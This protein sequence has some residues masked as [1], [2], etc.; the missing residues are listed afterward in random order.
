MCCTVHEARLSNTII[1]AAKANHPVHG[2]VN[3]LGYQ[4]TVEAY[5]SEPNA[6]I[7]PVPA[8]S[9]SAENIVD[10]TLFSEIL[11][12]Y[13]SE[14]EE[15]TFGEDDDIQIRG[16][17]A[18]SAAVE[19][20]KSGSYTVLLSESLASA[21][22]ALAKLDLPSYSKPTLPFRMIAPLSQLYRKWPFAVCCF[23]AVTRNQEPFFLWYKPLP[24]Y[25]DVLFAPAIDAHDGGPPKQEMVYR[26]HTLIFSDEQADAIPTLNDAI[27]EVPEAHRWMFTTKVKGQTVQGPYANGDFIRSQ[28]GTKIQDPWSHGLHRI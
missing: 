16:M 17:A 28:L 7:L 2:P 9:L 27:S 4:N 14:T 23:D 6:M 20:V 22:I 15:H 10:A 13:R 19:I 12:T 18:A 21:V 3:V 25:E 8:V 24:G 5:S 26:D 1:Y 11:K